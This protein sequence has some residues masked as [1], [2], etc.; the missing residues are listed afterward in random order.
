MVS[1]I[2]DGSPDPEV[3]SSPVPEELRLLVRSNLGS[4]SVLALNLP[5]PATVRISVF[6][7]NGR[8]V[9]LLADEARPAGSHAWALAGHEN[10]G[11]RLPAGVYLVRAD[12]ATGGRARA[13][14]ANLVLVR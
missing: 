4:E 10:G 8:R 5:E 3:P 1:S 11:Y 9:A 13:L 6:D 2:R 12:V 14:R 7:L